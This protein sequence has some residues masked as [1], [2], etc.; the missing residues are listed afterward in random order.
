MRACLVIAVLVMSA[1]AAVAGPKGKDVDAMDSNG[2][3]ALMR[4]AQSDETAEIAS[5]LDRGANIEASNPKVYGGATPLVIALEFGQSDAAKLLLDRGASIAGK[6]GTDALVLAARGGDDVILDR[7]IA[8]KVS[9]KNTLALHAAARYG[10]VSA[11]QKLV[12]A[13]AQVRA[14][15]KNDHDYTAFIVACQEGQVDAARVLLLM[16]ANVNDVDADGTPALH[17]AVFAERPVEIH[18][19]SDMGGPH[20][21]YFEPRKTAPLV[22]LLVDKR[23]K[24]DVTDT[25]GNTALHKAAMMDAA[26]AAKVLLAA[27]AKRATKNKE[28]KTA[29]ELAKS[30]KNSVEPILRPK[31]P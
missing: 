16:G 19:Y 13:G 21:T 12:K 25:D 9:P 10:H 4:A 1:S 3:T 5:L 8:A 17:W 26:A 2:W 27:G 23:A 31:T 7:L 11:L 14:K 30:R 28:G 20:D 15:N 6:K 22:K 24:L 29:Y 18:E